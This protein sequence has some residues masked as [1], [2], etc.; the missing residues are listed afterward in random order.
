M[1]DQSNAASHEPTQVRF[2]ADAPVAIDNIYH[3]LNQDV[4]EAA[5]GYDLDHDE[6]L[7][8]IWKMLLLDFFEGGAKSHEVHDLVRQ[9]YACF[10]HGSP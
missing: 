4:R 9:V 8:E 3:L 10:K 2:A 6:I 7:A 1:A 5:Q